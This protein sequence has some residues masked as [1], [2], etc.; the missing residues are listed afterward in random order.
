M[1]IGG[2]LET[3]GLTRNEVKVYLSLLSIGF[4]TTGI[5]I[6]KTGLHGSKVYDALERL[7]QKG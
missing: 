2:T 6:K 5:L 4:T 3:I 1:E 7:S